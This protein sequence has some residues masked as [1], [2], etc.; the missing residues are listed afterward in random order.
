M[1]DSPVLKS[2]SVAL[3]VGAGSGIGEAIAVSLAG[4]GCRVIC[5]GRRLE[6]LRRLAGRLGSGAHPLRLDVKYL[7]AEMEKRQMPNREYAFTK[8]VG[9]KTSYTL[10]DDD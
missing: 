6:R 5:A 2:G 1:A 9:G 8:I 3:V 7:D 10:P 4:R